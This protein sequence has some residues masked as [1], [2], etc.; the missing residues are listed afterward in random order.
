MKKKILRHLAFASLVIGHLGGAE[1][2]PASNDCGTISW[3]MTPDAN[4]YADLWYIQCGTGASVKAGPHTYKV[5]DAKIGTP[6]NLGPEG[7]GTNLTP[8]EVVK[9]WGGGD[10]SNNFQ[11]GEAIVIASCGRML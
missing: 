5:T 8:G 7:T 4:W 11:C 2:V 3:Y 1:A 9:D 10:R 6:I